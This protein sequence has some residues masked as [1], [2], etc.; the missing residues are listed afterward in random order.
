MIADLYYSF[1]NSKKCQI[2]QNKRKIRF[3]N[4]K[5]IKAMSRN[6]IESMKKNK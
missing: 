5:F 2:V 3:E 1:L 4:N 6:P